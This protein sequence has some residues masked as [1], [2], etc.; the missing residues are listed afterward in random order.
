MQTVKE[1]AQRAKA[2]QSTVALLSEIQ[3][4]RALQS[5][6][7]TLRSHKSKIT[8][9]NAED[10]RAGQKAGLR[11]SLLD[12]LLL[13]DERVEAMAC[14]VE[15]VIRLPDP[16]GRV[17]SGE[18]MKD[19]M[20]LLNI[21]VP[22]GVCG[23]IYEARPNVTVDAA[24]LCLKAGN[25][26]VLK[27]GKEAIRSNTLC[28]D[29][30]RS[31][32][33]KAGVPA[34]AMQLIKDTSRNA[35]VALMHCKDDLDVLI[36]RG[37]AGL[38]AS[39]VE[40]AKVPVIE[41]GTGNNHLYVDAG[42]DL[43][44]AESIL[45]NAKTQRPS[46]CNAV[47]TLL[48]HASEAETFLPVVQAAMESRGVT[49]RVCE[50]CAAMLTKA[51]E[52]ATESDWET[53]YIDLILAVRIVKDMTEA[54]HHIRRY[55]SGHSEAIVTNDYTRAAR[56]QQEV[57]AAAVYVNCSTRFTDGGE[58]GLGAEIGISTQKLHV[59]GPMGLSALTSNKYLISGNGQI[60]K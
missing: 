21:R 22:L 32:I 14:A 27:G 20:K 50:K 42:A 40:N 58:F 44:L 9:A 26:S 41:T 54:L 49:L 60:R 15:D 31:A 8:Q 13:T 33:E 56:F 39:V 24:S 23:I 2:V 11:A 10:I 53:E 43:E 6:A 38:I 37:G 7:D 36:P 30:M 29:L 12:R 45:I 57:D 34:D 4:N 17:L 55:G 52:Q 18:T 5:I 59:R 25:V 28:M 35:A 1:I 47:E 16:V 19:G 3:K 48:I 51:V 46:V